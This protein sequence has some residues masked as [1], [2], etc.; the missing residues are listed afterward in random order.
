MLIDQKEVVRRIEVRV[1]SGKNMG[2]VAGHIVFENYKEPYYF[3]RKKFNKQ[4]VWYKPEY[5]NYL[6][7]SKDIIE[8]DLDK[9]EIKTVVFLMTG[10]D[11]DPFYLIVPIKDFK[12]GKVIKFDDEQY[13]VDM[14]RYVRIDFRQNNI[15]MFVVEA[16]RQKEVI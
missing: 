13:V 11:K 6:A 3:V 14:T 1:R 10:F 12:Q 5:R 8:T 15:N 7:L 2:F 16:S 4:Q 9:R